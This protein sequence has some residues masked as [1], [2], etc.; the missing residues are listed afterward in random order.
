[1]HIKLGTK[2]VRDKSI[3]IIIVKLK[4]EIFLQGDEKT[5][6]FLEKVVDFLHFRSCQNCMV[7]AKPIV[8]IQ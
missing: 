1:M 2:R 8:E 3:Q 5:R 7:S 6:F 4:Y